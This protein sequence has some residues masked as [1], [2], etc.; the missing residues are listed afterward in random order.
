V[1]DRAA[2]YGTDE[3]RQTEGQQVASRR[4]IS[5][6]DPIVSAFCAD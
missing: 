4:S 5:A 1:S 6:P 3:R 2:G